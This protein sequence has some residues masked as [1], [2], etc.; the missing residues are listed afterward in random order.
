MIHS[1]GLLLALILCLPAVGCRQSDN[2]VVGRWQRTNQPSEWFQFE[3]DNTFTARSYG[4]DTAVLRGSF[5][6]RGRTV[7]VTSE[8]GHTRR[9]ELGDSLLVMEDGTK[10][11]RVK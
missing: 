10:Y 2:S 7:T 6:Q 8:Y 5:A 9:L 1:R 11:H 3:H 4:L